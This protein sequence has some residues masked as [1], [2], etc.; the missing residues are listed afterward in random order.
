MCRQLPRAA[1]CFGLLLAPPLSQQAVDRRRLSAYSPLGS[2]CSWRGSWKLE[3]ASGVTPGTP[4]LRP[5]PAGGCER[6]PDAARAPRLWYIRCP[7]GY[8][9]LHRVTSGGKDWQRLSQPRGTNFIPLGPSANQELH[10][11][12][13]AVAA[14]SPDVRQ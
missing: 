2:V 7:H 6:R 5:R 4:R 8:L 1:H 9:M 11:F 10:T 13:L 14:R 3:A 12:Q